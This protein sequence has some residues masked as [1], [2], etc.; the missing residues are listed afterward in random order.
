MKFNYLVVPVLFWSFSAFATVSTHEVAISDS[1]KL[2]FPQ[3]KTVDSI[4]KTPIPGLFEARVNGS[5]LIYVDAKGEH[6]VQGQLIELKTKRNI[7]Q[8]KIE[9]LTAIKFEDL[10]LKDSFT[11]VKGTGARKIA[12]FADPNCGFCKRFERDLAS[13]ENVTAHIFLYPVLGADSMEKSKAI[14]CSKNPVTAWQ[15]FMLRDVPVPALAEGCDTSAITRVMDF[16]RKAK[17]SGTPTIIFQSGKRVPG[18]IDAA[19]I[20]RQLSLKP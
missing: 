3:I 9:K 14:W 8:E 5:D 1:L 18:A 13:V 16:G 17:I 4:S 12:V 10:P 15:D 6:M 20:E 7:T 11:I 19:A 2:A